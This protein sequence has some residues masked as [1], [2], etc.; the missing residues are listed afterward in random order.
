MAEVT[1]EN[2]I[3]DIRLGVQTIVTK[4][5]VTIYHR[6]SGAGSREWHGRVRHTWEAGALE[7]GVPYDLVAEDGRKGPIA[8]STVW[9]LPPRKQITFE[10]LGP[11]E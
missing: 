10:G 5:A 2:L 3:V 11:L 1:D 9:G 8:I 7:F 4:L 6:V